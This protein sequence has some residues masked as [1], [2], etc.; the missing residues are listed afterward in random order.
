M[1]KISSETELRLIEIAAIEIVPYQAIL[2]A[3]I[4][5]GSVLQVQQAAAFVRI[6]EF[7]SN[8]SPTIFSRG[9]ES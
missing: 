3:W 1:I 2:V 7:F 9:C 5:L 4:R 8:S 6:L